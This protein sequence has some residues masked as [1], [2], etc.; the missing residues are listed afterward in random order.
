MAR[1]RARRVFRALVAAL[2]A[3][4]VARAERRASDRDEWRPRASAAGEARRVRAARA[5]LSGLVAPVSRAAKGRGERDRRASVA[6]EARRVRV[7]QAAPS[8]LVAPVGRAAKSR[9][10]RVRRVSAAAAG[11]RV[12]RARTAPTRE[13]VAPAGRPGNVRAARDLPASAAADVRLHPHLA[14]S[15][16][17]TDARWEIPS[18]SWSAC[19][20]RAFGCYCSEAPTTTK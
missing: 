12:R 13:R 20:G 2:R 3:G 17:R 1:A 18:V 7:A 10:E 15:A 6:V 8:G 19:P 16:A 14:R 11:R 5:A 9:G 4:R